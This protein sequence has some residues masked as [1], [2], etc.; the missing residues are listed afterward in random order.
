MMVSPRGRQEV[1]V[2]EVKESVIPGCAEI[3]PRIFQDVRGDFVKVY[4][5]SFYAGLGMCTRYTDEFYSRSRQGVVR[6]LHFQLPPLEQAKM[7]FCTSGSVFDAVVDLRKFSPTY[8]MSAT[9]ELSASRANVIYIPAGLAHGFLCTSEEAVMVYRVETPWSK[10]FDGGIHWDSV[11]I[12]WPLEGEP[13]LSDRDRA[14]KGL[15]DFESPFE[16]R[17]PGR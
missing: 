14:L 7:V 16:Y 13:I 1:R 10:E 2:F 4:D 6:G 12:D 11:G 17:E 9:F 5:A 3:Q 15:A 8:G